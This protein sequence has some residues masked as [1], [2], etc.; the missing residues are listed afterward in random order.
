[1][2]EVPAVRDFLDRCDCV[3]GTG[4]AC[5]KNSDTPYKR[6]K[7]VIQPFVSILYHD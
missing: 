5:A 3:D 4:K 1:M 2:V 7:N 6:Q